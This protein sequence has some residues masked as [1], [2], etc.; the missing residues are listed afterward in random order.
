M[1]RQVSAYTEKYRDKNIQEIMYT[2]PTR[3]WKAMIACIFI[4]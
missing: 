2:Y 1:D 3:I 4:K